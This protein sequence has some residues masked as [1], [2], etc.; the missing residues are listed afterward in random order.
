ML[1][2]GRLLSMTFGEL[3]ELD[4]LSPQKS[5]KSTS[6]LPR[7]AATLTSGSTRHTPSIHCTSPEQIGSTDNR[8]ASLAVYISPLQ[9]L[10]LHRAHSSRQISPEIEIP[11]QARSS[12]DVPFLVPSFCQSICEN[13][14]DLHIGGDQVLPL[15]ANDGKLRFCVEAQPAGPF[16]QS[17]DVPSAV[18]DSLL[19]QTSQGG[20]LH[21]LR[22]GSNRWRQGSALDRSF[23]FQGRE[24]PFSN[25]LLNHYLEQKLLD[26]YQQYMMENMARG[27]SDQEPICPLLGSELVLTSLDQITMKLSREGNLEA[28]LAKDMVLSCLLRVAGDKNSSE[29]STPILQISNESSREQLTE[30]KEE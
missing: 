11:A 28:S 8:S 21:P 18:D 20:L 14:S 9:S 19:G 25:S 23:L 26:L 12:G 22:G 29:I 27:H 16:L 2:E 6:G 24:G 5:L 30:Q 3:E 15:S 4:T 13:Y 1:C 17:C 7:A 10:G